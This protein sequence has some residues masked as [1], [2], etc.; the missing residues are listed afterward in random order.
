[1][2]STP[3]IH[4]PPFTFLTLDCLQSPP[5][6][7]VWERLEVPK[8][9]SE[10]V[11]NLNSFNL[12]NNSKT[13]N[14]AGSWK[15]W[16]LNQNLIEPI[17]KLIIAS[18]NVTFNFND[19][20]IEE[21]VIEM[22]R[23]FFESANIKNLMINL[24]NCSIKQQNSL[25]LELKKFGSQILNQVVEFSFAV[26]TNENLKSSFAAQIFLS[27]LLNSFPLTENKKD[28]EKHQSLKTL[29]L[30]LTGSNFDFLD[31]ALRLRRIE[32]QMRVD[33]KNFSHLEIFLNKGLEQTQLLGLSEFMKLFDSDD[34]SDLKLFFEGGGENFLNEGKVEYF[35][36]LGDFPKLQFLA[37]NFDCCIYKQKTAIDAIAKLINFKNIE[38]FSF[39]QSS[40]DKNPLKNNIFASRMKLMSDNLKDLTLNLSNS[41]LT[42]KK[43]NIYMRSLY[44]LQ[45]IEKISLFIQDNKLTNLKP[46]F[47]LIKKSRNLKSFILT[48]KNNAIEPIAIRNFLKQMNESRCS[49]LQEI[50]LDFEGNMVIERRDNS[51]IRQEIQKIV[52]KNKKL[53]NFKMSMDVEENINSDDKR[54]EEKWKTIVKCVNFRKV[55]ATRLG[56]VNEK[57]LKTIFRRELIEEMMKGMNQESNF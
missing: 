8:S 9:H 45:N 53:I 25:N 22:T 41:L 4:H 27:E 37:I 23:V 28:F 13:H 16:L 3:S 49:S 32:G 24:N 39:D 18:T 20:F 7:S 57:K 12:Q 56:L 33:F 46:I 52:L 47:E 17:K 5:F 40:L 51:E 14:K 11:L 26:W 36:F 43:L 42:S 21:N 48:C 15:N 44:S 1:M 55:M 6:G 2:S 34:L 10:L 54:E 30:Y 31:F 50:L 19:C 29:K 35:R 38:M